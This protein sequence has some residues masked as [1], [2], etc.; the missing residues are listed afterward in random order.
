MKHFIIV[1]LGTV[2]LCT[3]SVYSQTRDLNYYLELSMEN[4]PLLKDYNSRMV[5]NKIDSLIQRANFNPTVGFS[6][7]GVYAPDVKGYGYDR[8]N[9]D[10]E[11]FNALL[12]IHQAIIGRKNRATQLEAYK[13]ENQ[14]VQTSQK[15]SQQELRVA[16]T[17]QYIAAYGNLQEKDYQEEIVGILQKEGELLKTLTEK[18]VYKQTDYLNFQISLQQ[19]VL[20]LQQQRASYKDKVAVLNYL[21]GKVDTSEVVLEAPDLV[22]QLSTSYESTLQYRQFQIDSLKN[23]NSDALIDY[24]YHPKVNAFADAGFNSTFAERPYRNMGAS[25]GLTLSVPFYDGG[26]RKK[27]HQ[28]IKLQEQVRQDYQTFSQHQYEQQLVQLY[29]QLAQTEGIIRQ[30]QLIVVQTLTLIKAYS[31]LLQNGEASITDYVLALNNY[32]DAKHA[33]Q[34]N[35]NNK[36]QIINQINYWNHEQ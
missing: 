33:E 17:T 15:L 13:L 27:Q 31:R 26:Q 34:M 19:Q 25:I 35:R 3:L 16:I 21:C 28:K 1:W 4:S 36:L 20:L 14:A 7:G 23:K 2:M 22:P 11:N 5:M 29:Q 32:L 9:V 24:D 8:A 30:A 6:T 18:S 10:R 12:S